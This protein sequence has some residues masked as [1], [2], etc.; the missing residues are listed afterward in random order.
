MHP[1]CS[2]ILVSGM[3]PLVFLQPLLLVVPGSWESL[4]VSEFGVAFTV[5]SVLCFSM[6]I[7]ARLAA[8]RVAKS[9]Q[10]SDQAMA[11][12]VEQVRR[13]RRRER[14]L[15]DCGHESP[16]SSPLLLRVASSSAG[17]VYAGPPRDCHAAAG[18]QSAALRHAPR[19][20][21][22]VV[23]LGHHRLRRARRL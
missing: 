10:A 6:N 14:C 9:K 4:H 2:V 21:R 15:S 12:L 3:I 8:S 17:R 1:P 20:A 5:E 19:G 11:Q 13:R 7:M 23:P 18:R 22:T 16:L